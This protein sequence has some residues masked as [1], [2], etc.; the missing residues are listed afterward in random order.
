MLVTLTLLSLLAREP[1]PDGC[2]T[3]CNADLSKCMERCGGNQ[4][5]VDGCNRR[6]QPCMSGCSSASEAAHRDEQ[7]K[8]NKMPCSVDSEK[9]TSTPCTDKEVK[10]MNEKVKGR[11]EFCKDPKGNVAPCPGEADKANAAMKKAGISL[12]CKDENGNPAMCPKKK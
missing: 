12:D 5:C 3:R 4:K 1:K 8:A 10:A 2:L 6:G 11:K 7:A 9:H